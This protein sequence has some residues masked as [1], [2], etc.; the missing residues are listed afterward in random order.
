MSN[1]SD[2]YI[3]DTETPTGPLSARNLQDYAQCPRKYLLSALATRAQTRRHIGGPA[4]LHRAVRTALVEMYSAGE[5]AAYSLDALLA[6]YEEAWDGSAC[7]DS[8]E[9]DDLHRDGVRILTAQHS[10]PL[11]LT[12]PVTT[13]VR[14][15]Y[16][17]DGNAVV[18]VADVIA[19]E[20]PRAY[21]FVTSRRPPSQEAMAK[22]L[23]W[24]LLALLAG[25]HTE[26]PDAECILVDL[27][28]S[29]TVPFSLDADQRARHEARIVSLAGRIRRDRKFEAIKGRECRWCRS[30]RECP[31]WRK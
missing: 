30:R 18:A 21:R 20:P 9:E 12:G 24:A 10:E 22:D 16:E 3:L 17:I 25:R 28:K 23:S 27:R 15:E 8:R 2:G 4:A 31:A 13:D 11:P 14:L 26:N 5:P 6:A 7:K 29:C 19:D 1:S